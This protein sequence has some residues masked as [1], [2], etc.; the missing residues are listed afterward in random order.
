MHTENAN[1]VLIAQSSGVRHSSFHSS[2]LVLVDRAV[3]RK[4]IIASDVVLAERRDPG[5]IGDSG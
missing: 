3:L 4:N 2:L 5:S 1:Y